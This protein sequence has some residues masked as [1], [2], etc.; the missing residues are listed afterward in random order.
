MHAPKVLSCDAG[1]RHWRRSSRLPA[2]AALVIAIVFLSLSSCS[3]LPPVHAYDGPPRR[4][5]EVARVAAV[6]YNERSILRGLGE[7]LYIDMVDKRP[8]YDPLAVTTA[9]QPTTVF[10]LPGE[11]T[12]TLLWV[13]GPRQLTAT[14]RLSTLA[15]HEYRILQA[16]ENE[17]LKLWSE[18]VTKR[19]YVADVQGTDVRYID[20][21]V[22]HDRNSNAQR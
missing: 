10:V 21:R 18:D 4:L 8:T 17:Q 5:S 19:Q 11:H 16:L 13:A 3:A 12:F 14:L 1:G 22:A 20:A 7:R 6:S 15:G 9:T 2:A